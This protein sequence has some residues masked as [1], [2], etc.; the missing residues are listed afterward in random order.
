MWGE[1]PVIVIEIVV[2]SFGVCVG[3]NALSKWYVVCLLDSNSIGE[4]LTLQ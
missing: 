4:V 1:I 2:A 3:S